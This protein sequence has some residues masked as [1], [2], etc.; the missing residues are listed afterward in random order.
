VSGNEIVIG[1]VDCLFDVVAGNSKG[2]SS[3]Q[4]VWDSGGKCRK[5]ISDAAPSTIS[6]PADVDGKP[7]VQFKCLKIMV[8]ERI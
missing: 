5:K 2:L 6:T 8:G 4:S 7:E 3:E 1:S